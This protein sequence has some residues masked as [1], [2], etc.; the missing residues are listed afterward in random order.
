MNLSCRFS[1]TKHTTPPSFLRNSHTHFSKNTC[2]TFVK[3]CNH[4]KP[5][6]SLPPP[7]TKASFGLLRFRTCKLSHP[8]A[9]LSSFAE[10]EGEGG[11]HHHQHEHE[12]EH[13]AGPNNGQCEDEL[14]GIAK[15]FNVSSGIAS[16]ISICMALAVLTFPLFMSSVVQGLTLKMKVLSYATLLFGFYMAWN[17]GANDVANAMGTSVG[18]GALTLRQAVLTAAVLEFSGAL[19]MGTHVTSTMQKGILV[20][21]VFNGKDSLLFAGLLSS[22]AA[23]G[24]WLQCA[25]YYGW[26]VSTTHCI[27]GAM[28]GFGLAY[29]GAGAV[30]WGSLARVISSWVVSPL[31]G[32]AVS[33]LVYKCIRRFV[34]S[35]PNPGQAAAAAAPIAVFLGVTGI[36]FVAFPLSKMFPLALTQALASGTIGAFLVDR[37]IR[38]QL[39]HLLVKSNAP[40][41][42]AKEETVHQSIGFLSD[43]AGPKGTQLEIVYGVFG[44]MQVLSAC[45][46]SFAH[47]GNDV[48]NAIGPL[49]G[50]L[51]ILQGG[52]AGTEIVIPI[53]VLAW[54][55]FGIVAGLMM[56]GY[57]VIATIGKKITELT[58]TRGFA[59]EFAAASVVLF[60]SKL[61]L[62]ISATHTLVGA[63]MGVGFA[64]GLN[65]V[66]SETVKEIVASWVVTIPVGAILS[67]IYTWILTKILSYIL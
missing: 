52:A 2:Q 60:A 3:E 40:Q 47:G 17:I 56:W 41:P 19:M 14:P 43:V 22:L 51:A 54:G 15:A 7:I 62:P 64:R 21:N 38:K 65:R 49:A 1:S 16:A 25:S 37:I 48:S 30:F 67:V 18:S 23:A 36:S 29:G 35:A 44:Y 55:G 53:D 58:P 61:G 26:P 45:F 42:E 28:V 12:H 59:A 33:F 20:A 57:R 9:T 4:V 46:M 66:R 27:V 6:I 11:H 50:A 39:G 24:T 31:M 5:V 8:F 32:A 10:A 63:V 34:Y 13:D